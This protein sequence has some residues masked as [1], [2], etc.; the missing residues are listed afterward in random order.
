MSDQQLTF[1][2]VDARSGGYLIEPTEPELLGKVA[3]GE[4]LDDGASR[5]EGPLPAMAAIAID[6]VGGRDQR[7]L[8]A[9]KAVREG[10]DPL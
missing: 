8:D 4:E 1:N 6:R 7:F 3:R 9:D 5:V 2:G 10:M